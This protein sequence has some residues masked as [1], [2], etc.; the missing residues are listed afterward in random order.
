MLKDGCYFHNVRLLKSQRTVFCRNNGFFISYNL[1]QFLRRGI[2]ENPY[3]TLLFSI[4][5]W[6]VGNVGGK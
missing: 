6:D 2:Q 5:R 3:F 4:L 1:L